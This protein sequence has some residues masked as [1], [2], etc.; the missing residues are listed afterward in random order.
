MIVLTTEHIAAYESS[1]AVEVTPGIDSLR[2]T[3]HLPA[4]TL[5]VGETLAVGGELRK[6][7]RDAGQD[8]SPHVSSE[9]QAHLDTATLTSEGMYTWE[10]ACG[11]A[12]LHAHPDHG[13][14]FTGS[15]VVEVRPVPAA[16]LFHKITAA[17]TVASGATGDVGTR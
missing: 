8:T 11:Y 13:V 2:F 16:A 6:V 1:L 10:F 15:P 3:I 12:A 17:A 4:R 5:T 7:L 9:H 14:W